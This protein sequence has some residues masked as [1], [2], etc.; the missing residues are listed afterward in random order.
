MRRKWIARCTYQRWNSSMTERI[1]HYQRKAATE[2]Y[3]SS[4]FYRVCEVDGQNDCFFDRA[5]SRADSMPEVPGIGL[6]ELAGDD[7][8]KPPFKS[9]SRVLYRTSRY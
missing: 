3:S 1:A 2:V 7:S 8:E 4:R 9:T 6:T 5:C